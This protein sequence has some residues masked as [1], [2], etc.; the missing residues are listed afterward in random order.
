MKWFAYDSLPYKGKVS[1]L[2]LFLFSALESLFVQLWF[3]YIVTRSPLKVA[4]KSQQKFLSEL[5][6]EW[7]H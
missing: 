3:V 6:F 2:L 4:K 5:N 1:R 7:D